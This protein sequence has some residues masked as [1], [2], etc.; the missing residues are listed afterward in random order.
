M[1]F[2]LLL[3]EG[4]FT[5]ERGNNSKCIVGWGHLKTFSGASGPEEIL[6]CM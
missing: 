4:S 3:G 1:L 2:I 6:K 5:F